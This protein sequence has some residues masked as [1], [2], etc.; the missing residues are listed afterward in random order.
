MNKEWCHLHNPIKQIRSIR[1]KCLVI[2]IG[3]RQLGHQDETN[4][5]DYDRKGK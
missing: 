5:V 2:T 3:I 1:T 4:N